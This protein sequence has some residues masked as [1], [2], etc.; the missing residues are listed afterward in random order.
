MLTVWAGSTRAAGNDPDFQMG[1]QV[2]SGTPLRLY[3][4]KRVWYRLNAP[5]HA[6]LIEPVWAFDRIVVPAGSTLEGRIARLDPV[7]RL[8]RTYA[9]VG[10][11]FTP[12]KRAAVTFGECYFPDR[13]RKELHTAGAFGLA[14]IYAPPRPSKKRSKPHA[15]GAIRQQ[16]EQQI[17][18]QINARTRGLYDFVRGP[19]KREW[20]LNFV[21]SK[22]PYHPQ[23]YR[24]GTRFDAL[25][26]QPLNFGTVDINPRVLA[27]LG[28]APPADTSAQ[29]RIVET[30]NSGN[31]RVG[32]PVRGMLTKPVFTSDH[33]LILPQG[34]EL[35]GR[36]TLAQH[37]KM[38]H[39]GG[40]LRFAIEEVELPPALAALAHSARRSGTVQA[41]LVAAE[42]NSSAIKVDQEGTAKA[43]ESKT[44]LLRPIVAGLVA[45]KSMDN[46][47][48]KQTASG[49]GGSNVSG[50]SLGGFSGFGLLGIAVAQGPRQIG[51]ALG[52][53]GLSWSVYINVV[54]RGGE[55]RFEKNGEVAVRFGANPRP[56]QNQ[57]RSDAGAR[58]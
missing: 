44:R 28:A 39:R 12:L 4:T 42:S 8:A 53:Y 49:S 15:E 45:A 52:F 54:S 6:K 37:A 18:A 10:G 35:N 55:V 29:M 20:L 19:N 16:A 38:F 33:R 43:T 9:M 50:R 34:A 11:D 2:D 17:Q 26:T 47:A 32:N 24:S 25:L 58:R 22:L 3:I 30:V 13:T 36:I 7:S 40:R 23:W 31:A 51:T 57:I 21:M 14:T 48:G 5:V 41:Q 27:S 56:G 1:L 46:D